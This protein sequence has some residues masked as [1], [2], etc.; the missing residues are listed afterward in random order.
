MIAKR[1]PLCAALYAVSLI[2][3][4][5]AVILQYTFDGLVVTDDAPYAASTVASGMTAGGFT[6]AAGLG[7]NGNWNSTSNGIDVTSGATPPAYAQKPIAFT[8]QGDSFTGDAYWSIS[9][10]PEAGNSISLT[11][12]TFDLTV[13]NSGRSPSYYLSSNVDGF[14]TPIGSV[15]TNQTSGAVTIDLSGAQFQN[16]SSGTELR[17]YLWS[18]NGAGSSGS[19]WLFDNVTVNGSVAVP[20]PASLALVA[21]GGVS[22]ALVRRSRREG[23]DE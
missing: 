18:E 19:R 14:S 6:P 13:F 20:E 10:A 3:S 22:L 8:T 7:S 12:L 1:L 15:A 5:A 17:L 21:L 4:H 16:L 2:S 9:L 11:S 23:R